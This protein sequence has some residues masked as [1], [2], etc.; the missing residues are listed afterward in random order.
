MSA[1]K[2]LHLDQCIEKAAVID[3]KLASKRPDHIG[4]N[5][6]DEQRRRVRSFG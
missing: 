3:R 1:E 5:K 2:R 6:K 4:L